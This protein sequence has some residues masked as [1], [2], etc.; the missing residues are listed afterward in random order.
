PPSVSDTAAG[1]RSAPLF[2]S[3]TL[4]GSSSGGTAVSLGQVL[5][6]AQ[7]TGL[8]FTPAANVL[9]QSSSLAYTVADPAGNTTGGTA[10][11][12]IGPENPA[13]APPPASHSPTA[14]AASSPTHH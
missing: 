6:V 7:L 8:S 5:S 10:A 14:N 2:P 13:P 12:T 9:G 11:L 4:S 3:P 1:P